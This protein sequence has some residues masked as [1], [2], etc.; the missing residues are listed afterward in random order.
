MT[1]TEF[2]KTYRWSCKTYQNT[3]SL[4]CENMDAVIGTCST[5]TYEKRGRR[6]VMTKHENQEPISVSYYMNSLDAVPFFRNLGGREK[7]DLSYTKLGYLPVQ[8]SSISPDRQTKIVRRFN[9]I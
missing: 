4:C 6:W 2:K 1:Y 3:Q 5:A 8:I 9:F 7:V